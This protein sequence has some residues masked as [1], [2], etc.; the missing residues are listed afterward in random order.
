LP[1]SVPYLGTKLKYIFENIIS[2]NANVDSATGKEEKK[3]FNS[4]YELFLDY[5]EFST[6]QG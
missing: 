1:K 5:I 3:E 4:L 2:G 6:I